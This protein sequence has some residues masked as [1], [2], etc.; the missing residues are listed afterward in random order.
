MDAHAQT[1]AVEHGHDGQHLVARLEHGVGGDDLRA[2]RVE[3]Q[4]GQQNA[5][6]HAGG[7]AA[8]E[9]D[10]GI[11]GRAGH[12]GIGDVLAQRHELLP[13][14]AASVLGQLGNLAALSHGVAQL[15]H[16]LQAVLDAADHQR[17]E[18]GRVAANAGELLI[19]HVHGDGRDGLGIVQIELD[20][21]LGGQGM[22]HVGDGADLVDGVEHDDGHRHVGQADGHALV[23]PDAA[24]LQ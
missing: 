20:L 15:H 11:V 8:V 7:S 1:E 16:R 17:L 2:Q 12:P 4:V 13:A 18:L 9:N 3:V 23:G 22:D 24:G 21:A 6:G 5:L 14:K 19:E 10:G